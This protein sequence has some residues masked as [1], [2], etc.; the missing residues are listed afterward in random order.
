MWML[1]EQTGEEENF[2]EITG[3]FQTRSTISAVMQK[4]TKDFPGNGCGNVH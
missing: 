1:P 3:S 2:P 4:Y